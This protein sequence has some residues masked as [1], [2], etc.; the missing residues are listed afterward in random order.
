VHPKLAAIHRR[1]VAPSSGRYERHLHVHLIR[2][3]SS[4]SRG[5][6]REIFGILM[7][8]ADLGRIVKEAGR[9]V[10]PCRA[11]EKKQRQMEE[12]HRPTSGVED[13][14]MAECGV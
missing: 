14:P 10:A 12:S 11:I 7:K 13:G 4:S 2:E 1:T 3:Y 6:K 8:D 9:P 5:K